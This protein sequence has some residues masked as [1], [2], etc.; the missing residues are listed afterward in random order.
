MK[1][2]NNDTAQ[3]EETFDPCPLCGLT[4][5][6]DTKGQKEITLVECRKCGLTLYGENRDELVK[7]WNTRTTNIYTRV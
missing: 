5:H 2:W 6:I 1:Q 3:Y 7:K 4:E